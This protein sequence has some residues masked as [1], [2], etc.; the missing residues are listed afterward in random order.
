MIL[1]YNFTVILEL[2]I[3]EFE[4]LSVI[5]DSFSIVSQST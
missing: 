5:C 4:M 3:Y 2:Q 1:I